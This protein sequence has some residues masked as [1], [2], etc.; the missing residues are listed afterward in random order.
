MN[1]HY[2]SLLDGLFRLTGNWHDAQDLLQELA[3]FMLR[4]K[5]PEEKLMHFGLLRTKAYQLFVDHY[6]AQVRR[7]RFEVL[8]D[9][10]PEMPVEF[11]AETI[12]SPAEEARIEAHFWES[13]PGIELTDLQRRLIWQHSRHG[14]TFAELSAGYGIPISTIGDWIKLA[15][16]RIAAALNAQR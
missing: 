11:A 12:S 15:R 9:E 1:L 4:T 8:T 13:L 10:L 2:A 7:K 6:R 5:I 3:R 16:K 14:Y